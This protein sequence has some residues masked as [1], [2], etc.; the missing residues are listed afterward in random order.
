[1]NRGRAS[2]PIPRPLPAKA[3]GHRPLV[4]ASAAAATK[5]TTMRP[6][7]MR[8]SRTSVTEAASVTARAASN[9]SR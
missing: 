5:P 3:S 6:F 2:V 8:R 9:P 1:M 7:E 4:V